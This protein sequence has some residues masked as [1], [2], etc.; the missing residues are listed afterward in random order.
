MKALVTGSAGFIGSH[1]AETLVARGDDVT[2]IDR[3]KAR[4]DGARVVTADLLSA[5]L[6]NVDVVFHLAGRPGVRQSWRGLD[7][8]LDDNVLT[9][10]RVL[11]HARRTGARVVFASSSSVYGSGR[12]GEML[13]IS[14][15]GVTKLAVEHL[16]R[17]Y[18]EAYHVHAVGLRYF[19]VYGP[20]QRT[21]MAFHR[22]ISAALDDQAVDVYG[23]G[24]QQRHFTYV[25]DVVRATILA[26]TVEPGVYDVAAGE[27]A[28]ILDALDMIGQ[29]L[30]RPVRV[31]HLPAAVGDP[32]EITPGRLA[33][34]GFRARTEPQDGLAAQIAEILTVREALAA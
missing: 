28:S 15:Y 20:R 13:P 22:F 32:V 18:H 33:L 5:A 10:R 14:P 24:E 31:R 30:G 4:I 6:P 29:L 11:D 1:L 25:V 34:P 26:A 17:A 9:T 19:T 12:D 16:A 27:S 7:R 2:A 23:S 3:R 21:D 8:Y